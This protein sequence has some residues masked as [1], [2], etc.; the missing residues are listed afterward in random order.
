M[1]LAAQ[2]AMAFCAALETAINLAIAMDPQAR[3]RFARFSGKVIAVDLQDTGLVLYFFPHADG[4]QLM[5]QYSGEADTT[6]RGRPLALA[7]LSLQN[8]LQVLFDG[9]VTIHGDVE[10]GQRFKRAIESIDIDWEEHLSRVT[11]DVIA[12]RAGHMIREMAGWW[13]SSQQ[14][15]V[16]NSLEYLQQEIR[17]IPTRDEVE[18]FYTELDTLRDDVARLRARLKPFTSEA[19]K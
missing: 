2:T 3:P 13:R 4:L 12:H 9:E 19:E 16:L 1:G 15:G 17:V 5:T 7:R 6:I 11:G 14:R 18:A 8:N 10:L